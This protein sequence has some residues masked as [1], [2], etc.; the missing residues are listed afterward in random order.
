MTENERLIK[1]M[2]KDGV[3][4]LLSTIYADD[5]QKMLSERLAH[6]EEKHQETFLK[7]TEEERRAYSEAF[8][9]NLQVS[10]FR[11]L[12]GRHFQYDANGPRFEEDF[13]DI[14]GLA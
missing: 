7:E 10:V 9:H 14:P 6:L 2:I 5:F 1:E 3:D 11:Q 8:Y 4:K 13:S 12:M